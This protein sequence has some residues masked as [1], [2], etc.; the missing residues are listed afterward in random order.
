MR[1]FPKEKTPLP[2]KLLF[3]V[4]DAGFP[5]NNIYKVQA[6]RTVALG[7]VIVATAAKE[8]CVENDRP[9]LAAEVIN[10]NNYRRILRRAP[11]RKDGSPDHSALQEERYATFIGISCCM[12][13]A[14]PRALELIRIYKNLPE[15]LRPK[16][17]IVGG[18]HAMDKAKEFLEAGADVVVHGE[19]ELIIKNLLL[20]L[21][22][23]KPL[24]EIPGISFWSDGQ[25]QKN[26]PT[27][28]QIPQEMM[29]ALPDPD[30]GLVR[31]ALIKIFP[32][33]RTRGCSGRCRFCRV[34]TTPRSISPKRFLE[35]LIILISKGA[36]D[37]FVIDDRSE[38]DIDGYLA[39]LKGLAEFRQKR[40]LNGVT[41]MT[42]NRLSLAEKPEV[43]QIMW[44]AG[45]RATAIGFESPIPEEL[46]AMRKPL[47]PEK[48]LE[49]AKVWKEF[50]FFIH[51]MLIFGYP[52][53]PEAKERL[54]ARGKTFKMS[55]KQRGKYFW[56]FI[57]KVNP[58]TLQVLLYTPLPNTEDREFLE[59]E[60]R[61]LSNNWE[62]YD[63]TWLLFKPDEGV[64]PQGLQQEFIKLM[65]KFYAFHYFWRLGFIPLLFHLINIGV[66]TIAMP[67][68][69]PFVGFR[70]WY[71]VWRNGLMRFSG[72]LIV[73]AW[74]KNFKKIN[75][76][77][78]LTRF[79]SSKQT[80]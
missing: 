63:G 58:D 18:W 79:T 44:Q 39:W 2:D 22:D 24:T 42:Q 13:T 41:L 65:R 15:N 14:A 57:K 11:C 9:W 27:E 17:I 32:V 33:G 54:R 61:I 19:A 36:K 50:G 5:R 60:G 3:R 40:R 21:R 64:D 4:I 30:F 73:Q 45:I 47:K 68:V 1:F 66:I 55:A 75:F 12:S 69:W 49:W 37:I 78:K 43:L 80:I 77:E 26:S 56:N 51:M 8:W 28:I 10:E 48:M 16:A 67:F 76:I 31:Y 7:P 6:K 74:L 25:I 46:Q 62:L 53:S 23:N 34:R 35:Q 38:E 71:Q 29:D 59:Q 70:P 52:L 20:A 72:H